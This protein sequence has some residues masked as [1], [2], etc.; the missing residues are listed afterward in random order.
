M[1]L[2][3]I[4]E[5]I[6]RRKRRWLLIFVPIIVLYLIAAFRFVTEPEADLV[7]PFY[8]TTISF[9]VGQSPFEDQDLS[10]EDRYNNWLSSQFIAV[11]VFDWVNGTDFSIRLQ[12]RLKEKGIVVSL[13]DLKEGRSIQAV[14][15]SVVLS[16]ANSER[17]MVQA[18]AESAID[19]LVNDTT[20]LLPQ[21]GDSEVEFFQLDKIVISKVEPPT[22]RGPIWHFDQVPAKLP[23]ALIAG[24]ALFLLSWFFDP[25]V[26]ARQDVVRL[27]L[28]IL[29]EIPNR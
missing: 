28:P 8:S 6:K 10:D 3:Y 15:S 22:P 13:D 19:V 23:S 25:T 29:S 7:D 11:N 16:I 21:A 27:G 18:I 4:W 5:I 20:G 12:D 26:R 17:E 2:Q 14:R 9:V 24:V 1:R